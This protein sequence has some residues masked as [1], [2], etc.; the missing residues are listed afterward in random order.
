MSKLSQ[1]AKEDIKAVITSYCEGINHLEFNL[2]DLDQMVE[3]ISN[4]SEIRRNAEDAFNW[5]W[6]NGDDMGK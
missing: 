2:S 4:I 3:D 1:S 5:S 6:R